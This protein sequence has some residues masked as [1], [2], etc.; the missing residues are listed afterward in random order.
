MTPF[1][2]QPEDQIAQLGEIG[3]IEKITKWMEPIS[4]PPPFGIGDDCAVM[5]SG[6]VGT[7]LTTVDALIWNEHF[8]DTFTPEEAGAKLVKRNLSDI[9]AMGGAPAGAVIALTLADNVSVSWLERFY[10]GIC[11]TALQNYFLIVG[12]DVTRGGAKDFFGSHLTLMGSVPRAIRRQ[13]GQ[14]AGDFILVTGDLGG[15][16]HGKEKTFQP[17]LSEGQWFGEQNV[18]K[19]MIDV[20][21]GLAKDIPALLPDGCCAHLDIASVPISDAAKALAAKTG[22]TALEHALCDGE[23]YELLVVLDSEV[24]PQ[25]MIDEWAKKYDSPLTLIGKIA[26]A[27]EGQN[28]KLIDATSGALIDAAAFEHFGQ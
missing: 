20:T 14:K 10:A 19:G 25:L 23:D 7:I 9:A 24:D 3:L 1:T 5:D 28:R 16:R 12:G 13:G 8:D 22:K 27:A 26:P 17:L 6:D 21:D 18:V 2:D 11:E 4:P 15:T